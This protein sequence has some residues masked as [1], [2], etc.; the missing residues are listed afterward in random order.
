MH[1]MEGVFNSKQAHNTAA[2]VVLPVQKD[3][4][5]T[6]PVNVRKT[7]NS[8]TTN[9]STQRYTDSI[10]ASA[11]IFAK[12]DNIVPLESASLP[13]Q[14]QPLPIALG[15]VSRSKTTPNIVVHVAMFARADNPA[16]TAYVIAPQVSPS[17]TVCVLIY[18]ITQSTVGN[19]TQPVGV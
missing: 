1:V 19:V 14:N 12:T 17:V 6:G 5:V 7:Y 4:R 8:A 16:K 3:K 11:E 15:D 18:K 9:V 13:A 2:P 10:V